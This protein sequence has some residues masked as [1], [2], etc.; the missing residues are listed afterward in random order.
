MTSGI[1][2]I[3]LG[4]PA[5]PTPKAVGKFLKEFLSDPYVVEIPRPIWWIILNCFIL[6]KRSKDAAESTWL[7]AASMSDFAASLSKSSNSSRRR[8]RA[9]QPLRPRRSQAPR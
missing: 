6:P 3:N 5:E 7:T 2:L 1:L 9:E 4:T 8:P